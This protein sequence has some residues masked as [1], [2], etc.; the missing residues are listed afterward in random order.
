MNETR[1]MLE[2]RK[3]SPIEN[4]IAHYVDEREIQLTALEVKLKERY[5]AAF[6]MLI[7]KDSILSVV[8]KMQKLYNISPATAYRDLRAA[9]LIFGTVKKFDK[10]AWRFIQ[11]ERKRKLIKKAIKAGELELAAR[12]E[13][14][15][16]KII[17]FNKEE[18]AFNIDK[19]KAM[20]IEITL[21]SGTEKMLSNLFKK[22]VVDLNDMPAY[23]TEFEELDNESK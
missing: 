3:D 16:D 7:E 21:S 9:E 8:K 20:N 12:L 15:I 17:D 14:D 22:G 18:A 4:I 6:T 19:L 11:I 13:R 10:E 2:P 5:E 23:D 1:L